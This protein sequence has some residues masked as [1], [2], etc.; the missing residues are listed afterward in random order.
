MLREY[1]FGHTIQYMI[2]KCQK[3]S[4]TLQ[5]TTKILRTTEIINYLL[6]NVHHSEKNTILIHTD[7][8]DCY[9]DKLHIN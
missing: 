4:F 6:Y 7:H 3:I 1:S 8:Y 2:N 5:N 9:S